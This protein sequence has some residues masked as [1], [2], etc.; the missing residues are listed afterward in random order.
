MML[1]SESVAAIRQ[2]YDRNLSLY[3]HWSESVGVWQQT[4]DHAPNWRNYAARES[5]IVAQKHRRISYDKACGY[6]D[7]CNALMADMLAIG[8]M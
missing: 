7:A 6:R 2:A 8:A 1:S 3:R 5:M 4:L